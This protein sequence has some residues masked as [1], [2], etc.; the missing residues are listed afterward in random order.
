MM[1]MNEWEVAALQWEKVAQQATRRAEAAES[2]AHNLS[3][4]YVVTL[5]RLR[6]IG[7]R[8][9][10]VSNYQDD[11]IVNRLC[12]FGLVTGDPIFQESA[13][14]IARYQRQLREMAEALEGVISVADRKT[15]EFDRARA[16]LASRPVT[17]P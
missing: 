7:E 6:E 5:N 9:T 15:V 12:H 2:R 10:I 17:D 1:D 16:A 11:D 4:K 8:H 13:A 14:V 3:V